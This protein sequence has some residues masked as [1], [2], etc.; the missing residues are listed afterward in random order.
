MK[1]TLSKPS[2]IVALLFL[3]PAYGFAQSAPDDRFSISL[4]AF[5]TDRDSDTRLDSDT[6]G[7]GT[8]INLEEDLGLDS[9]DSVFRIDGHIRFGERHR[10][11]FSVFDLSRDSSKAIQRDI[12]YGDQI[13]AIDTVV[14]ANFDLTI[15]KL[16][17]TYSLM[18]RDKG[19]LGVTLGAYVADSTISLGEP[20]LGQAEV[21]EITAPLPV[22]GLRGEYEFSDRWTLSASGEFFAIEY[23]NVDGSLVDLYFGID[24]QII[25]HVAIGLGFNSVNIDV[26]ATKSDFDGSL[27]WQYDGAL[28]F[29][30]FDF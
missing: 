23:D 24:Y 15:Y 28:I 8:T 9:S 3:A 2:V 21:G 12:Q 6:L 1:K 5:I 30:N 19:Y 29:F 17:Y 16:A 4:G 25:D 18:Q 14:N 7:T 13:F 22:I 27:D 11:T 20:N 10:A 26:D